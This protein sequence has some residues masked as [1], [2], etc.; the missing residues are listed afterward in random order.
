MKETLAA[1]FRAKLVQSRRM[2]VRLGEAGLSRDRWRRGS[3]E[4]RRV[5]YWSWPSWFHR[6]FT[7]VLGTLGAT[8]AGGG[9]VG[10]TGA[11]EGG[12]NHVVV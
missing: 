6:T 12:Y 7:L 2:E 11:E 9:T 1:R 5:S 4:E 10:Y 8:M 3:E